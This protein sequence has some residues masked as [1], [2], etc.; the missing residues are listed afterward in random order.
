[1]RSDFAPYAGFYER[2]LWPTWDRLVRRRSTHQTWLMLNAMQWLEKDQIEQYQVEQ[3]KRLLGHAKARIPYYRE[4]F[5]SCG[6]DPRG[7]TS[8]SDLDALPLLTREIVRERY[9]DL[10][11]R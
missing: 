2:V 3:L 7:I 9:A 11:A 10:V 4:L 1:M 5:Q 6:F 8:R